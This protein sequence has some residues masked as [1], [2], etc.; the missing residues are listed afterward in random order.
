MSAQFVTIQAPLYQVFSVASDLPKW[1]ELLS[2]YTGCKFLSSMPWGG[3]VKMSA[4]CW[5]L[6]VTWIAVYYIDTENQQLRFEH[7]SEK[8]RGVQEVWSFAQT[9]AGVVVSISQE[10]GGGL[11]KRLVEGLAGPVLQGLR[12]KTETAG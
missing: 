5:G 2:A 12:R 1:P 6:P 11:W 3:I 8:T 4:R 7:V 10:G 9:D